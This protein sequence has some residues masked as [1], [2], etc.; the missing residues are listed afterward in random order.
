MA[1]NQP[2]AVIQSH[3]QAHVNVCHLQSK[4]KA[5]ML[6]LRGL[7][8][9]VKEAQEQK[10]ARIADK[11]AL[12]SSLKD[13]SLLKRKIEQSMDSFVFSFGAEVPEKAADLD[14]E[15]QVVLVDYVSLKGEVERLV[16]QI[17]SSLTTSGSGGILEHSDDESMASTITDTEPEEEEKKEKEESESEQ[18]SP[19]LRNSLIGI[20]VVLIF[21]YGLYLVIAHFNNSDSTAVSSGKKGFNL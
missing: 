17:H 6:A 2:E 18:K 12:L 8:E 3:H 10:E 13:L 1:D 16:R 19:C 5:K 20:V 15:Y 21:Y 11:E 14:K 7:M 9:S 4:F